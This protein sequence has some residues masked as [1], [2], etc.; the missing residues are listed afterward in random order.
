MFSDEIIWRPVKFKLLFGT[1]ADP[2]LQARFK[3]V[4][5]M[6]TSVSDG[7][8]KSRVIDAIR[9]YFNVSNWD[10]GETFYYSELGAFIHRQLATAISSVEIVPVLGDSYFGNLREIRCN[11]DELFFATAQVSD[12]DIITANTPTNL[13][14]R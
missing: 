13:R 8:I 3:V 9:T 7:E 12:I 11:P 6:G 1:T 4:P 14:I 10:F 5:L 2:T